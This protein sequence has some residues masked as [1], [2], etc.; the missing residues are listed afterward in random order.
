MASSTELLRLAAEALDRGED[1]FGTGF[2][3]EN[4]VTSEQCTALCRQLAI[5]ARIVAEGIERPRSEQGIGM[6]MSLAEKL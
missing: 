2:L 3:A 4:D 6:M 5:G 1:P